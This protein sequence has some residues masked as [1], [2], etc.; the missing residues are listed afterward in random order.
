MIEINKNPSAGDLK[1]FGLIFAFFFALIGTFIGWR[2]ENWNITLIMSIIGG[3]VCVVFYAI[4]PLKQPIFVGWLYLTYPIGFVVS[5]V[6]LA[7]TYYLVLTPIGLM[8]R[9]AGKDP[10]QRTLEPDAATYWEPRKKIAARK[11][12]F[13]QY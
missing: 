1:W 9:L 12:Y 5:H 3:S 2:F 4:P 13:K 10:M 8:M 6:I 7:G 11:R